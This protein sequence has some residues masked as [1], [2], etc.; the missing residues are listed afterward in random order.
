VDADL[1]VLSTPLVQHDDAQE[2]AQML[3]VPLGQDRFFFEAH[4]KLRPID[5]ASDGIFLAGTAHGPKDIE[6]SI[7]QAFGVASRSLTFLKAGQVLSEP[8]VAVVDEGTCIGCGNC[9]EVC[10]YGA[11]ALKKGGKRGQVAEVNPGLC[12]GCGTCPGACPSSSIQQLGFTDGQI[13]AMIKALA[14]GGD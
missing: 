10:P 13:L 11:I 5:F 1:V 2:L 12:K 3:R 8:I 4:V 9:I 14:E 6:E 7:V